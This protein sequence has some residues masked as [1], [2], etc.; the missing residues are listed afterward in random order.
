MFLFMGA[1]AFAHMCALICAT[2]RYK[3]SAARTAHMRVLPNLERIL[4]MMCAHEVILSTF[5]CKFG[6]DMAIFFIKL[7]Q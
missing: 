6:A 4:G 7:G 1:V 3:N 5:V 2:R